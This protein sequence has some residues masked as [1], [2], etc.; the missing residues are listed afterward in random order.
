MSTQDAALAAQQ[1]AATFAARQE[2]E[3]AKTLF[4]AGAISQQ[5][6]DAGA[7]ERSTRR[8]RS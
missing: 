7:G 5:E 8:S 1:A 2:L 6:L 4:A 3:R